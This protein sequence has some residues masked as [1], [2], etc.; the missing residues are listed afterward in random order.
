M[1]YYGRKEIDDTLVFYANTHDPSDGSAS[2]A[3]A[4]PTYRV[5]EQETT[6]PILTGSMALLDSV[7]TTGFYSESIALSAANGFE[8]GK[9]YSVYIEAAV[10]GVT[11]TTHHN[12]DVGVQIAQETTVIADT[13]AILT[14]TEASQTSETTIIADTE[15]LLV[16]TEAAITERS[17]LLTDT[18]ALLVD[19]EATL[20]DT[21]AAITE[22]S[23]L[24]TDTEAVLADTEAA[25][26]S[27]TT[28]ISD[29]EAI[30]AD[31]EAV[32]ADSET[33]LVDTEAILADT[34]LWNTAQAEPTGVPSATA[35]PLTKL[36]ILYMISR[37]KLTVSASK[38]Q[39]Y[40][41]AGNVEFEQDLMDNGT[42]FSQSQINAP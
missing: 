19:T 24:L 2:D 13:E 31:S 40:D 32:I 30:L 18:E 25:G 21:E 41:N 9:N 15:A 23:T 38:K 7:N 33:I 11:G 26:T 35:S 39:F 1:A 12:W 29:T 14:D 10:G 22:R 3:D 42:T 27:F 5:Y 36:G 6:T 20:T 34:E 28:V 8:V 16:D 4:P 17:T 37:N